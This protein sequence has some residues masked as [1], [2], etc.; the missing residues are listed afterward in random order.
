VYYFSWEKKTK[1]YRSCAP[2]D[3]QPSIQALGIFEP[4]FLSRARKPRSLFGAIVVITQLELRTGHPSFAV[5]YD[6]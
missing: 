4:S 3:L 5:M 1:G 6:Q 2:R